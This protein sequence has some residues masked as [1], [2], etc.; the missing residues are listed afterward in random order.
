MRQIKENSKSE[1]SEK[2]MRVLSTN[3]PLDFSK[4]LRNSGHTQKKRKKDD[5][6]IETEK[7]R[8][9]MWDEMNPDKQSNEDFF[10]TIYEK[11][12][13]K[14]H[15]IC[16]Q[17]TF[18]EIS[19]FLKERKKRVWVPRIR[20]SKTGSQKSMKIDKREDHEKQI[21][22]NISKNLKENFPRRLSSAEM[23]QEFL[24]P[25]SKGKK[26][27]FQKQS[28]NTHSESLKVISANKLEQLNLENF[29]K[30]SKTEEVDDNVIESMGEINVDKRFSKD[31]RTE[32]FNIFHDNLSLRG[33]SRASGVSLGHVKSKNLGSADSL[34]WGPTSSGRKSKVL[35]NFRIEDTFKSLQKQVKPAKQTK[36]K[37]GKGLTPD[38]EA[39]SRNLTSLDHSNSAI[40]PVKR[41]RKISS[42]EIISEQPIRDRLKNEKLN[43]SA[44][45]YKPSDPELIPKTK[46]APK[47]LMEMVGRSRSGRIRRKTKEEVNPLV[48][49]MG[50]HESEGKMK[51]AMGCHCTNTKCV[52]RYCPCF[53]N[54]NLCGSKC[55][56]T[57][58]MNRK[59]HMKIRD[60]IKSV[61]ADKDDLGYPKRFQMVQVQI[62]REN[63]DTV[64]EGRS[65]GNFR[66][67]NQYQRLQLH[68]EQMP[69]ELLRVL[70]FENRLH[71][72]LCVRQVPQ[73]NGANYCAKE[74]WK[75]KDKLQNLQGKLQID[76]GS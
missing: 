75:P 49:L 11:K 7:T 6:T 69:Q 54:N 46:T 14:Y 62:I 25:G 13:D 45:K 63:G 38:F 15:T 66:T 40:K 4:I 24:I 1:L 72:S 76:Q 26:L 23:N 59:E 32:S 29:T 53:K 60:K 37:G 39:V 44:Q 3:F 30:K 68:Q 57:Q 16:D 61:L 50:K 19:A 74:V 12:K 67:Q 2:N 51:K 18:E 17:N 36:Q 58:C 34:P 8:E 21:K 73:P 56:C 47:E 52:Q 65:E 27:S 10:V 55:K 31:Q 41:R 5:F 20:V 64:I 9:K 71:F 35:G 28:Q 33:K 42:L 70:Q 43:K 48:K 22:R